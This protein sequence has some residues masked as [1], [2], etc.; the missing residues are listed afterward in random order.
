VA[1]TVQLAAYGSLQKALALADRVKDGE[2]FVTPVPLGRRSVWYRVL[3]GSYPTR[4]SAAAARIALWRR[5]TVPKGQGK[6][7]RAPYSLELDGAPDL[8]R[9]RQRGIVALTGTGSA[10]ALVGAFESPEQASFTQAQLTR[11]GIEATLI[12]RVETTP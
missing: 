1:W 3:V 4:D 5:R 10:S 7:L 12:T 8:H 2:A 6:L 11:A 9:L